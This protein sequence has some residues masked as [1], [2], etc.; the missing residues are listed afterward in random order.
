MRVK[1]KLEFDKWYYTYLD[2]NGELCMSDEAPSRDDK[3]LGWFHPEL[4]RCI[5]RPFFVPDPKNR[6]QDFYFQT[7]AS[8]NV[9]RFFE[10][11]GEKGSGN[12]QA[13]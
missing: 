4:G 2:E 12:I 1:A 7:F 9:Q 13:R 5:M 6:V 8:G 11:G 3:R 10:E